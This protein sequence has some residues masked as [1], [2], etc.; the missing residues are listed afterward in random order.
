MWNERYSEQG[1]AYGTK[2]NDFLQANINSLTKGKTLCLAEGEGRNAV[3]LAMHGSDVT[4]VDLSSVGLEKAQRLADENG[5]A[6]KTIVADLSDFE[7]EE[8]SWDTIVSIW[9]HVP[10]IVRRSLHTKVVAG[11]KPKGTFLLEA[12]T[13][14]QVEFGTGGPKIDLTMSLEMLRQEL[15]PLRFEISQEIEREV[16]EG[17]YHNGHSAVV[18]ILAVR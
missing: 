3:F 7:I 15:S 13:P 17:K 11:L 12:Y 4:A 1:F 16:Q 9:A 6:I 10:A 8:N 2:P 14:K 18:Q 5:V